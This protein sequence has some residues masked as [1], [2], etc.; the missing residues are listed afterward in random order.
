MRHEARSA[1][2]MQ[3][4]RKAG[5]QLRKEGGLTSDSAINTQRAEPMGYEGKTG[6]TFKCNRFK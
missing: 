3:E 1:E 2:M 5:E 6:N 4:N